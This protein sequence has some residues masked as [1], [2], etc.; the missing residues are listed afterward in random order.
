MAPAKDGNYEA[1]SLPNEQHLGREN[2]N[3]LECSTPDDGEQV[4]DN[5]ATQNKTAY[6]N[7]ALE[8]SLSH[9]E[10]KLFYQGHQLEQSQQ[11]SEWYSPLPRAQPFS[12]VVD[13]KKGL[14]HATRTSSM[15][16]RNHGFRDWSR[17]QPTQAVELSLQSPSAKHTGINGS[18]TDPLHATGNA[19]VEDDAQQE[20][21]F[22]DVA[23]TGSDISPELSAICIHIRRVLDIRRRYIQLSLQG[24]GENPRDWPNWKIYPSPPNPTWDENK[25]R[26]IGQNPE[27]SN[28]SKSKSEAESIFDSTN[29][30][31]PLKTSAPES[32]KSKPRKPGHDIGDDFDIDDLLPL[33]CQDDD[34][35]FSLDESSVYQIHQASAIGPGIYPLVKVPTLRD[36][37]KDL[38]EIQAISADGPT[39]SFAYRQLDIMEGKFH[40]YSLENSYQETADSKKVPH[41]DFYNV[42]K[43]DTHVHHSSCMNQKHLLRFIKSKMKKCPNEIVMFRDGREL[44]LQQVFESINLTAY[45]LSIDTLDMHVSQAPILNRA[46]IHDP[47]AD[48]GARLTQTHFTA[49]ISSILSTTLLESLD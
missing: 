46:S 34:I 44:S 24:A 42:R 5:G 6:Y 31:S 29:I 22:G 21:N 14:N 45:D 11:S 26:P 28:F 1:S 17:R 47:N 3:L 13:A 16:T 20:H 49:L 8:K 18:E 39:K 19:Y 10:A 33:P 43:V 4:M 9:E 41:R 38:D 2:S 37:Y 40:L 15:G 12:S 23:T 30:N 36:F 32:P 25:N 27:G 48:N 35:T 7:A